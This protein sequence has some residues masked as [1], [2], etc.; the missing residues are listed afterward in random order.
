MS[1]NY[2]DEGIPIAI[3]FYSER[4]KKNKMVSLDES[5]PKGLDEDMITQEHLELVYGKEAVKRKASAD[6]KRKELIEEIKEK[7]ILRDEVRA[8]TK[9][10]FKAFPDITKERTVWFLSGQSGSG[11]SYYS[12]SLLDMYRKFGIKH[13]FIVTTQ[14][15]PKFG[16][17]DY[18]DVNKIVIPSKKDNGYVNQMD[19]YK[20]AK[21]KFKLQKKQM[22]KD[23]IDLDTIIELEL[24]IEKMKPDKGKDVTSYQIYD[25]KKFE[26]DYGNSV[27]L[28]D[29]YENMDE[30]TLKKVKFLRDHMLTT[31]RHYHANMII[32]NHL[33]NFG[34]DSRLIMAETHC[35]VLFNKGTARSKKYFLQNYLDMD[36]KQVK[37]VLKS[38][39]NSRSV[40]ICPDKKYCLYEKLIYL[41]D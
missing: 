7:N 28:F 39:N 33:T 29:D 17:A 26:K 13:V 31:G 4:S 36:K 16:K 1:L 35:F 9:S 2:D 40:T 37:R 25:L 34:G 22:M 15:D 3:Q 14:E 27:W 19:A 21:M 18:V 5:T 20:K 38:L 8:D 10:T 30:A 12:A 6:R 24:E 41:Y 11:K 32:C 23:D